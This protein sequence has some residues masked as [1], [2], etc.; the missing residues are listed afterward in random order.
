[1]EVG[2]RTRYR[3]VVI[4]VAGLALLLAACGQARGAAPPRAAAPTATDTPKPIATPTLARATALVWQARTAPFPLPANPNA[5]NAGPTPGFALTQADA[6]SAYACTPDTKASGVHVWLTHDGGAHWSPTTDIATS[7]PATRCDLVADQ[8]DPAIVIAEIYGPS[9]ANCTPCYPGP[10]FSVVSVDGGT[11]WAPENGPFDTVFEMAT[12]QGITYALFRPHVEDLAPIMTT[13]VMSSDHLR[14]WSALPTPPVS[15]PPPDPGGEGIVRFW[16]NPFSGA[17]LA[18]TS[19]E[20]EYQD[21]FW[22][23]SGPGQPWRGISAPPYPFDNDNIIVQQPYTAAPWVFCGADPANWFDGKQY[24][25]HPHDIECS[26]DSGA[27]WHVL[28]LDESND[29]NNQPEYTLLAVADDGAVLLRSGTDV[30][31]VVLPSARIELMGTYPQAGALV[32]VAGGGVG[33]LWCGPFLGYPDP[34][35]GLYTAAYT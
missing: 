18:Q 16:L 12:R 21:A 9:P 22:T 1:M 35:G 7:V 34:Q 11:T 5:A 27:T 8:I 15:T 23:S 31:R 10:A 24:N 32:Y 20:I 30:A 4:V 6:N 26:R 33:A 13:L 25:P 17:L 19:D 14:T 28:H 2:M 3:P 29:Q